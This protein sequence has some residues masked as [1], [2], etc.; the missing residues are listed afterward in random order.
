MSSRILVAVSSPW[1]SE[2]IA[3]PLADLASRLGAEV[4]VAHVAI[5][6]EADESELDAQNRAASTLAALAGALDPLGVRS[7]QVMLFGNDPARAI[8][9]AAH[10]QQA[11][12]L[13]LGLG[14]K[15]VLRRLVSGDVPSSILRQADLPVM[16][17]PANWDGLL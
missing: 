12:L 5:E 8:L 14:A 4:L 17:L 9:D 7:R 11:T 10:E 1:A 6:H 2:K 15:G 13:V 3:R 16:L